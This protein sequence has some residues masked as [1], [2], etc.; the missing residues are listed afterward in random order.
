MQVKK[1][2]AVVL[3]N[4]ADLTNRVMLELTKNKELGMDS[5][6]YVTDVNLPHACLNQLLSKVRS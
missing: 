2:N 1:N 5:D 4:A 6:K 3:T